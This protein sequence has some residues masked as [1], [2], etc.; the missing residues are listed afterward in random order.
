MHRA[1]LKPLLAGVLTGF[2]GITAWSCSVMWNGGI[3]PTQTPSATEQAA[4]ARPVSWYYRLDRLRGEP[5]MRVRVG[6]DV[7]TLT[8][9]GPRRVTLTPPAGADELLIVETPLTITRVGGRFR[10]RFAQEDLSFDDAPGAA[11]TIKPLGDELLRLDDDPV[12]GVV[13][14]VPTGAGGFDIVERV[15][16]EAYLPGVI[17]KELYSNWHPE[18]FKAQAIA[19]R[20][21]ALHERA[22]RRSIGSAFDVEN[23]TADQVYGGATTHEV[24]HRAVRETAG[25]VLAWEG[26]VLRAYYSSTTGPRAAS[27]ADTWP[28]E[29]EFAFN[30]ARPIQATPRGEEDKLSPRWNWS[31]TRD[32]GTLARRFGAF[33]SDRGSTLRRL[34]TIRSIEP[35]ARN[36]FDRP[37][38]YRVVE[39]NGD[40]HEL[41]AEDLRVAMNFRAPGV[42]K[43]E[44]RVYSSDFRV[45]IAAG[46]ATITGQG[47]GHGVGMSQFG[48]QAKALAGETA[49]DIL[50]WYYPGAELAR[51]Y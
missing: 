43:P 27:A 45:L 9:T 46:K 50:M 12:P 25:V 51:A 7:E 31:V 14:L 21:Y 2:L 33:G 34:R 16:I 24:A 39:R 30:L 26:S 29:G 23:T 13:A 4:P 48:A 32:A 19:A 42:P 44:G 37:S 36:A 35:I 47:F 8:I 28:T 1:T 15:G 6:R 3:S 20:S 38:R 22:R 49:E 5:V 40:A 10:A 41:R 17:A 11:L 18:T